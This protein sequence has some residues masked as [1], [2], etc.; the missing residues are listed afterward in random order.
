GDQV[1]REVAAT[2]SGQIRATD[3]LGRWGGEEFMV[4]CPGIVAT[5]AIS[6]AE[7]LRQQVENLPLGVT[8][9][10]GL[11]GCLPGESMDGLIKRADKALYAAKHA[12]RNLVRMAA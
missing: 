8:I 9:S 4:L 2:V 6:I 7:K 3:A 10:C 1:L 12:G 5:D 11:A